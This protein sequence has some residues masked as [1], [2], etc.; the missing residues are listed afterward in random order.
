MARTSVSAAEKQKALHKAQKT[1]KIRRSV[2]VLAA[3]GGILATV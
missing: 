2:V 3:L 1:A